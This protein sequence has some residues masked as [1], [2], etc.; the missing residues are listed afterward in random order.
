V[1]LAIQSTCV[2]REYT[3]VPSPG[4]ED[5]ATPDTINICTQTDRLLT[6]LSSSEGNLERPPEVHV[7]PACLTACQVR[8]EQQIPA[9][10]HEIVVRWTWGCLWAVTPSSQH[11]HDCQVEI[12]GTA[13]N[14]GRLA[15][16]AWCCGPPVQ[17]A[18][19][20]D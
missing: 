11:G 10:W 12:P 4:C 18:H 7:R 5:R 13:A 9:D 20:N 19:V 2:L 15:G 3:S 14:I 17:L 6:S 8:E 1:D 16:A